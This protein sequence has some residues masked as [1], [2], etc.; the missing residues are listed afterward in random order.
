[1]H[2]YTGYVEGISRLRIPPLVMNDGPQGFR[3]PVGTS[4]AWPCGMALA[5]SFSPGLVYQIAKATGREFR[6][7]GAN[8]FL[9]PGLNV[10]RIPVNGRNFE[11]ISG[12]DPWLGK[13]MGFSYVSGIQSV[14]GI[15]AT[16]KHYVNNEQETNRGS[17]N[18]LIDLDVQQQ[19]YYPPFVGAIEAGSLSVMCSYNRINGHPGCSNAATLMRDLRSDFGFQG[20]V[21]SDW[22]A[23]RDTVQVFFSSPPSTF[24]R[25][26]TQFGPSTKKFIER[27]GRS[28]CR[29][30]H[31]VVL[32]TESN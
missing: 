28:R 7:K 17:V 10:A 22:F 12:E 20:Y 30:A 24:T 3:G 9:G 19:V 16:A 23:T 31:S 2:G 13:I 4:T 21:M 32:R 11:Y 27:F 5:S 29:N 25:I 18:A 14:P 1:V 6:T 26:L 8:V 15:M